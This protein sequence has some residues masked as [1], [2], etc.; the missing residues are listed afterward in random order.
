MYYYILYA[1]MPPYIIQTNRLGL[2]LW[3]EADIPPFIEMNRD[4]NVMR[5]FPALLTEDETHAMVQ[6]I[7]TGFADNGFGLYAVEVKHTNEFI[8]FTGFSIPRFESFFT[9]CIEIGWRLKHA[10]WGCGYATEAAKACLQYGFNTLGFDK[11]Y[12]FTAKVNTPSENVMKKAGMIKAGEFNHPS[13]PSHSPVC[14]HVLYVTHHPG[15]KI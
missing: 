9:P 4:A 8:G 13:I 5:Y 6:R 3:A 15:C 1:Y 10:A 11:V 7:Q 14:L 2:R 12:S